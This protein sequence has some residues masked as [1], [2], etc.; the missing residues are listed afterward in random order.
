MFKLRAK[1][2]EGFTAYGLIISVIG[3]C[4]LALCVLWG[5]IDISCRLF[6]A[7][8]PRESISARY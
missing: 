6:R 8:G 4:F 7:Q 3:E 1:T 5:M 2:T